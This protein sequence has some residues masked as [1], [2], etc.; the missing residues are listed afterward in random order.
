MREILKNYHLLCIINL[1][2]L[3]YYVRKNQRTFGEIIV[4]P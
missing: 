2:N 4:R 1:K 3:I